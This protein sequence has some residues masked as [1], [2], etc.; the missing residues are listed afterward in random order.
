MAARA[1]GC[2]ATRNV[3]TRVAEANHHRTQ[4]KQI[5]KRLVI[6]GSGIR[7]TTHIA[8]IVA[9][10]VATLIESGAS[11][12][13]DTHNARI[14]ILTQTTRALPIYETAHLQR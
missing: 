12:M 4:W 5:K 14:R 13:V 6:A 11:D 2:L 7:F 10:T 3:T 9:H 1:A 8:V